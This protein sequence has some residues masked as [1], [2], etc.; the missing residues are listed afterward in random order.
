MKLTA[1]YIKSQ[2]ELLKIAVSAFIGSIFVLGY[3]NLQINWAN[4]AVSVFML[5]SFVLL[6]ILLW[7]YSE[8][9]K[10]LLNE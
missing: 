4:P 5:V 3:Y 7:V 10:K 8:F 9:S 2:L 1:D 6:L